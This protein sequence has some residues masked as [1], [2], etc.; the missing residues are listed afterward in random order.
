[1]DALDPIM[2][3]DSDGKILSSDGE[4]DVKATME[5]KDLKIIKSDLGDKT[6]GKEDSINCKFTVDAG[7]NYTISNLGTETDVS[8]YNDKGYLSLKGKEIISADLTPGEEIIINGGENY[9]FTAV[10]D[11]DEKVAHNEI[12][13]ISVSATADGTVIIQ[14]F[15]DTVKITSEEGVRDLEIE[16][17]VGNESKPLEIKGQNDDALKAGEVVNV[18]ATDFKGGAPEPGS[19]ES[20]E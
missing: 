1:M 7:D 14:T 15:G 13:L 18:K 3:Q 12:G 10:T 8:I 6:E 11:M 20:A 9:S 5:V 19:R 17:F 16:S 4:T 2:I